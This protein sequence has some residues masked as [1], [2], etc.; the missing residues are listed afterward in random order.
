MEVGND[1]TPTLL[2]RLR[3]PPHN[4]LPPRHPPRTPPS[5]VLTLGNESLMN[6]TGQEGDAVPA[7]LVTEVLASHT[8]P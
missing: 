2:P 8:N 1:I 3:A 5:Q 4:N 7:D 6:G